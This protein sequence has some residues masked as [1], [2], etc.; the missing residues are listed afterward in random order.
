M[1]IASD[2][3]T[4]HTVCINIY[5]YISK[6]QRL[7]WDTINNKHN[8]EQTKTRTKT[9][10][11]FGYTVIICSGYLTESIISTSTD[12]KVNAMFISGCVGDIRAIHSTTRY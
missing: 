1:K 3:E 7:S 5:K 2:F 10:L 8:R 11:L 12:V 6:Q 9:N 4:G